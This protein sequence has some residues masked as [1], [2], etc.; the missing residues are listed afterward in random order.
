LVNSSLIEGERRLVACLSS[1]GKALT[2][3]AHLYDVTAHIRRSI[4]ISR[5]L[6]RPPLRTLFAIFA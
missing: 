6:E 4:N 2:R 1:G 3:T 5:E